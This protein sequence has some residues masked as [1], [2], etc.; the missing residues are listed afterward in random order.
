[1]AKPHRMIRR[2]Q[3]GEFIPLGETELKLLISKR[4]LKPV[5]LKPGS[6]AIGFTLA[7]V[8]EYQ[9]THMGLEPLADELDELDGN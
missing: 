3:L 7:S 6:R 1:M 4:L 2:K 5:R 9:R 8:A